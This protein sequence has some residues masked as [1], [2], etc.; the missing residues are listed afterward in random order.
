MHDYY[1]SLTT[2]II[3]IVP[4][5]DVWLSFVSPYYPTLCSVTLLYPVEL[6]GIHYVNLCLLLVYQQERSRKRKHYCRVAD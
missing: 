5:S 6:D 3:G 4:L 1:F 2:K